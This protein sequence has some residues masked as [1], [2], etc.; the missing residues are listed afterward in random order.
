[1]VLVFPH[2]CDCWH[3]PYSSPFSVSVSVGPTKNSPPTP[4]VVV[5]FNCFSNPFPIQPPEVFRG[6]RMGIRGGTMLSTRSIQGTT[7]VALDNNLSVVTNLSLFLNIQMDV[8]KMIPPY[9]F[10]RVFYYS[11]FA[12]YFF[13]PLISPSGWALFSRTST[14]EQAHLPIRA[15]ASSLLF[16]RLFSRLFWSF[17]LHI[18]RG[19]KWEQDLH[20]RSPR[21]CTG[22]GRGCPPL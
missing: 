2:S 17:R 13:F 16:S 7:L 9:Q 11:V 10:C 18:G 14:S 20:P 19:Q 1:M 6:L 12:V 3:V 8:R 5:F 22:R 4:F 21:G 15:L